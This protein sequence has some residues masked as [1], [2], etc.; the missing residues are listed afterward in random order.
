MANIASARKRAR[1][2]E[3]NRHQNMAVRSRFRTAVKKVLKAVKSGDRE[4]ATEAYRAAVPVIDKTVS[5]G[6]IHRNKAARHK[7]RLN[8]RIRSL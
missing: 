7:S 5:K 2:A 4:G 6:V 3:K 8:A 1:Q